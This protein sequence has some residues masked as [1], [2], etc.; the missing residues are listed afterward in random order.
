MHVGTALAT[1]AAQDPHAPLLTAGDIT[2]TRREL[3][4]AA[5][6]LAREYQELGVGHESRVA[7]ALPNGI[8]FFTVVHAVWKLGAVPVPVSP[9][10]TRIEQDQL[11]ALIDPVLLVGEGGG[12]SESVRRIA[13][14]YQA[15]THVSDEDLPVPPAMDFWKMA[16]SGGSTGLPKL[17]IPAQTSELT[18][19]AVSSLR[20]VAGQR[21]LVVGPLYH[22]SPFNWAMFGALSGQHLIVMERFDAALALQLIAK[23]QI[24][25]VCLVPTMMHRMARTIEADPMAFDLSSLETVWHMA[26]PCPE[27]LKRRWIELVGADVLMELYGTTEGLALTSISGEEWL[28]RPGSVGRPFQ[29]EIKIVDD[30]GA[31]AAA[32]VTGTVFMRNITAPRTYR[33]VGAEPHVIED[34]WQTMGDRGRLD[35]DGFLY[36]A[37]RTTDMILVGGIN[38]YPAETEGAIL[39]FPGVESCA[40]V[41]LPDDELGQRLHAVVEAPADFSTDDLEVFLRARLLRVKVPRSYRVVDEPL[42]NDA[43]KLRRAEI[44]EREIRTLEIATNGGQR[45]H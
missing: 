45:A 41:G 43:G 4:R 31:D 19:G 6:R 24:S 37:D 7:I 10:L 25:W 44:R 26:A 13:P 36:L 21:Q 42:R 17:I 1:L 32:D 34:G 33:Y 3:N 14:G 27:W 28:E 38:V 12:E 18:I 35:P 39:E 29:G 11:I 16:T 20:M 9:R 22:A 15:S 5:N 40:V 2:L 8:E 30:T 23:H